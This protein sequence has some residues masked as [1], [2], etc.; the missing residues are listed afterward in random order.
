MALNVIDFAQRRAAMRSGLREVP[1]QPGTPAGEELDLWVKELEAEI[2]YWR[3]EGRRI[4]GPR[5]SI[6]EAFLLGLTGGWSL[7]LMFLA[8]A[9]AY[10]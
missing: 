8:G 1:I 4:D 7:L 9:L 6:L 10:K 3:R 2:R 5:L